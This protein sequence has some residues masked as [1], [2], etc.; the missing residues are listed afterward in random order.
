MSKVMAVV[1]DLKT[2]FLSSGISALDTKSAFDE[3]EFL[4]SIEPHL[5]KE[6]KIPILTFENSTNSDVLPRQPKIE[7]H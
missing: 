4:K 2:E 3:L 7:F 1:I 6:L 5:K